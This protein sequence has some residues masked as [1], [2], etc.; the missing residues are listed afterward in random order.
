MAINKKEVNKLVLKSKETKK[1]SISVRKPSPK[2][3]K[4]E[5]NFGD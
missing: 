3:N 4:K 1:P 2:N 5:I